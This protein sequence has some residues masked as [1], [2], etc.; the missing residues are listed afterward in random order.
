M[1]KNYVMKRLETPKRVTLGDGRTFVARF[2]R[3]KRSELPNN[4]VMRRTYK[5]NF[6][7][8]SRRKKTG[9]RRGRKK[10]TGKGF[11]STLKKIA[12]N[13]ILRDIARTGAKYLPGLY[14]GGVNKIKNKKLKKVLQSNIA[15]RLVDNLSNKI[16]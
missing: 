1:K 13:P 12:K 14:Q 11:F 16:Q 10:Q 4:I 6:A 7:K 3:A 5:N 8:G 9:G 15:T 2:K